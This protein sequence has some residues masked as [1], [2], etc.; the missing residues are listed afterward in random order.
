MIEPVRFELSA[1]DIPETWYNIAA[2]LDYVAPVLSPA[3]GKPVTRDE[4]TRT[5]PEALVDQELSREAEF[6]IPGE[7]RQFYAR[8]RPAPLLRARGLEKA[9]DTPARIYFKYEGVAPTGS[10][11]PNS[12]IPQA[13]YNKRAGRTGLIAETGAGQWGSAVAF[14]ASLFGMDAKVFMVNVSFQQKPYRRALMETFGASCTPSPS[15]ETEAGRAVLKENPDHPGSL[16]I[17][18]SEALQVAFSDPRWGYTRGSALNHVCAH[19]TVIGQEAILQ[20][21]MAGDYPDIVVGCAGGGSN[22][23]GLSFPFLRAQLHGGPRI[24]FIAA[25]PAACPSLTQGRIAYDFSDT[26]GLT[27]LTRT[28]TLGHQFVPPS[29]HAGGLRAHNIAPL[30]SRVVEE[31]LMEAVALRQRD[32]FEAG[33]LFARTEGIVPAPES[34]HAIR[35]AVN[36]AIRCREEGVGKTILFGLSGHGNFDLSAYDRYLSGSLADDSIDPGALEHGL[37]SIPKLVNA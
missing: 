1:R 19:Q 9:L 28:H 14:A 21:E 15:M 13:Y 7:V 6:E 8:W 30:V 33:V 37:E 34:T 2:D 5:M 24:R 23:A 18:K 32:C 16:G 27:S 20:M 36:E 35:G 29:V 10:F 25:E 12:A 17:A 22:L 4:M 26:A 11:K 3:T 31:G